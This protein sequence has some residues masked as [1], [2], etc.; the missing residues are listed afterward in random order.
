MSVAVVSGANGFLGAHLVRALLAA[1]VS[2]RALVR[3]DSNVANLEGLSLEVQ[4]GDLTDDVFLRAV[5]ADATFFFH[6]AALY[7]QDP[8]CRREMYQVNVD[9]TRQILRVAAE[10]GCRRIVHTSTIGVIGQP[11]HGLADETTPYNLG[12]RASDYVRSKRLGELAALELAAAGAPIVVVNP[13]APVGA[14]DRVPTATGR[15]IVQV[16]AGKVPSYPP[17]GINFVP[18]KDVAAGMILAVERGKLGERYILGHRDGNLDLPAF[19]DVMGEVSGVHLRPPGSGWRGRM[20]R[21]FGS[22]KAPVMMGST[23]VRLTANPAKAIRELGMPQS[24]LRTA[25]PEA[26][27]RFR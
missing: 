4:R 23:P 2:V 8:S 24:D 16:L 18:A 9:W 13:C 5:F 6:L 12:D 3:S 20:R 17:G 26:V 19:L 27:A 21:L 25:F 7:T 1:H 14:Y 22:D 10:A 15:R 11:E